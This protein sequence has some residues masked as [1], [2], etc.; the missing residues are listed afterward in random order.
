MTFSTPAAAIA[1]TMLLAGPAAATI[2]KSRF[3][4]PRRLTF[5]GTGFAQPKITPAVNNPTNGNNTVPIGSMCTIGLNE[6]RPSKRAVGSP[7]RSAVQA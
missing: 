4:C 3:G 6:T 5:T 1:I 7:R 2:M